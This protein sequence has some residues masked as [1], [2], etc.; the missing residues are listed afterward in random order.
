MSEA[1]ELKT[2]MMDDDR[3]FVEV[4]KGRT[5]IAGAPYS[6]GDEGSLARCIKQLKDMALT[7]AHEKL[8]ARI[9]ECESARKAIAPTPLSEL[10]SQNPEMRAPLIDRILRRGETCNIIAAS[11]VGKSFL[12]AGLAWSVATGR[13]WLSHQVTK[14]KVLVID[15]ELH[16]ETLADRLKTIADAM[17]IEESDHNEI[18]T[19]T[20]RGLGIDVDSVGREISIPE[21]EYG[22][23]IVDALY[24]W[25]PSKCS[26]NDNGDM[27]RVYNRIDE[28]AARW[29]A[30]VVIVHHSSKGDQSEKAV[31]DVG[32]GAGAI[33]RAADTHLTIH[34]HDDPAL[35]VL[36]AVTRSWPRPDPFSIRYS[37]PIWERDGAVPALKNRRVSGDVRQEKKDAEGKEVILTTIPDG[38]S[39][40]TRELRN[41]VGMGDGRMRRL[42]GQLA[43]DG[44]VAFSKKKKRGANK[45]IEVVSKIPAEVGTEVGTVETSTT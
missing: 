14:C 36:E 21:G 30:A 3:I 22:L 42:L 9:L 38:K 45:A 37:Y 43:K 41:L 39:I 28:L 35:C 10:V 44:I 6:I 29:G 25:L 31:T 2:T 32:S 20:L 19:V 24:R 15:N 13:D 8:E 17:G 26:E 4:I 33:S 18:H 1:I 16:P 7:L 12:A 23:V 34:P 27:M 5:V 11:K 40:G